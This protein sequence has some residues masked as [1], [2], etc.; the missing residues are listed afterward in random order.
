M[1][2]SIFGLLACLSVCAFGAIPPLSD[3]DRESIASDIVVGEV[4]SVEQKVVDMGSAPG[5]NE[6]KNWLVTALIEVRSILKS[7]E[8]REA[9]E[10][11]KV[12]YWKVARR[13]QGWTGGQGQNAH[14]NPNSTVKLFLRSSS[15]SGEFDLLMPNGWEYAD[16]NLL[17]SL[18][19]SDDM[20]DAYDTYLE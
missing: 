8:I 13:P 12:H 6:H 14:L 18:E 7:T 15:E 20:P 10:M 1:K 5:R 11:I 9:G 2:K 19:D 4:L 3:A 17:L 16:S